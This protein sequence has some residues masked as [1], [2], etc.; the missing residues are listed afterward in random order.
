MSAVVSVLRRQRLAGF[1]GLTALAVLAAVLVDF[2]VLGAALARPQ[3]TDV[4]LLVSLAAL[5]R[6]WM[7]VKWCQLARAGGVSAP[8][9]EFLR[10][11]LAASLIS[12]VATA[13]L[14]GDLFRATRLGGRA[15]RHAVLAS[16]VMEKLIGSLASIA[17]AW[18]GLL[19]LGFTADAHG[20]QSIFVA[21]FAASCLAIGLLFLA[22]SP[23]THRAAGR[24]THR[25]FAKRLEKLSTATLRFRNARAALAGNGALALGEN[26]LQLVIL[27]LAA[28]TLGIDAPAEHLLPVLAVAQFARRA[29]NVL[30]GFGLQASVHVVLLSLVGIDASL[31]LALALLAHAAQV[32]ASLPGAFALLR[33]SRAG[34]QSRAYFTLHP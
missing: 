16:L 15:D 28:R 34:G 26:V 24:L 1:L 6:V 12:Q 14:P 20:A 17:L 2:R 10:C 25:L 21:L 9:T 23:H 13:S 29:S 8:F 7:A 11:Y 18:S 22:L 30:S 33:S 4:A 19:V 31:A 32:V 3:A 5:D 27:Y